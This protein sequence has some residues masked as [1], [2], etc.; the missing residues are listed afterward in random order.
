LPMCLIHTLSV[1]GV[2]G[3]V[4]HD[5]ECEAAVETVLPAAVQDRPH[6][7][8]RARVLGC[9]PWLGGELA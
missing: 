7:A 4:L 2:E 8:R 6:S 9:G 3:L 5:D 1:E